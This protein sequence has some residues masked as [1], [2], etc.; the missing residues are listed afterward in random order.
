MNEMKISAVHVEEICN[1]ALKKITET[2]TALDYAKQVESL[3]WIRAELIKLIPAQE[4]PKS[5]KA[6]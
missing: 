4:V 6:K 1:L 2:S 3:F 5:E